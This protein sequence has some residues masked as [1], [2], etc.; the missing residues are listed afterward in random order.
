M[1]MQMY[2]RL[3]CAM[4][5]TSAGSSIY[6]QLSIYRYSVSTMVSILV[7]EDCYGAGSLEVLQLVIWLCQFLCIR[8]TILTPKV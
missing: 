2:L 6:P 4:L 3:H 7:S 1:A 8:G 5:P